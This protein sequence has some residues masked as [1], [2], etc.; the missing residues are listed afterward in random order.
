MRLLVEILARELE[1]WPETLDNGVAVCAAQDGCGEVYFWKYTDINYSCEK[2]GWHHQSNQGIAGWIHTDFSIATDHATAIVTRE[3]W[4]AD[5]AKL[6]SAA[7]WSGEGLPPVGTMCEGLEYANWVKVEVIA[8]Y[9]GRAVCMLP[10]KERIAIADPDQL[11][12][13]IRT[14]E[15]IAA[16]ERERA[17]DDIYRIIRTVDRPGNKADMAEAIYEAG[18]RKQEQSE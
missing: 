11:R 13:V 4:E 6:A 2:K 18:Y 3:M 15:Q 10:C 17:L 12:P 7:E 1:E 9:E 16:Q 8:H 5:R 14:P